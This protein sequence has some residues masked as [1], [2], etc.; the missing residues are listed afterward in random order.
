MIQEIVPQTEGTA[1]GKPRPKHQFLEVM[2]FNLKARQ[3]LP[4]STSH[5]VLP[6]DFI[7][8]S[9]EGVNNDRRDT[10]PTH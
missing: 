6:F 5:P 4:N 2:R 7:G 9:T 3:V 10:T 1:F 8:P